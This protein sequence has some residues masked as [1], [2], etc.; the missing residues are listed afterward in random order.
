MTAPRR[1]VGD[2]PYSEIGIL[3][4]RE[5]SKAKGS[6]CVLSVF[7]GAKDGVGGKIENSI[8]AKLIKL[9]CGENHVYVFY[10]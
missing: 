7:S 5:E 2:A 1:S 8:D 10:F 6:N 9:E 4:D 3:R